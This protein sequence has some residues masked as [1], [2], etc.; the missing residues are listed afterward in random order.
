M[1]KLPLCPDYDVL[2]EVPQSA[3]NNVH[4][5]VLGTFY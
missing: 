1:L 4:P 5:T 2:E 3:E